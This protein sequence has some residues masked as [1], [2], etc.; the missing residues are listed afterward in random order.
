MDRRQ[1]DRWT[2]ERTNSLI[3]LSTVDKRLYSYARNLYAV[4][5]RLHILVITEHRRQTWPVAASLVLKLVVYHRSI[6]NTASS[7]TGTAAGQ[8]RHII[9]IK[10]HDPLPRHART[11]AIYLQKLDRTQVSDLPRREHVLVA[12]L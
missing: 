5:E 2:T 9:N 3:V 7:S 10:L 11:S 4:N 8:H 1:I 12:Q 6:H